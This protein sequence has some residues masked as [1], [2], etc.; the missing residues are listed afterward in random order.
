MNVFDAG[1]FAGGLSLLGMT[2]V[3]I[4]HLILLTNSV[5]NP[6]F[7][8]SLYLKSRKRLTK[9]LNFTIISLL[10]LNFLMIGICNPSLLN[11]GPN[12]L[13]VNYQNEQV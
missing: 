5:A 8:M 1:Y 13:T 2:L 12:S 6:S 9:F 3:T 11:P 7:K 4:A 10:L